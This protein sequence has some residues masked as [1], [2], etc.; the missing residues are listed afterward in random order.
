MN[1]H[2]RQASSDFSEYSDLWAPAGQDHVAYGAPVYY[3][4]GTNE[5]DEFDAL[6]DDDMSTDE[7]LALDG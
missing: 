6:L 3:D 2:Y 7:L 5:E 1:P 4:P